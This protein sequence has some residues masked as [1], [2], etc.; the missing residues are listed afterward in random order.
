MQVLK[1]GGTSV[2]NAENIN[3]VVAIVEQ[4]VKKDTAIIVVSALAGIT[5]ALINSAL[6]AS[7]G[8]EKYKDI[9][10]Q[11]EQRHIE[12]VKAL[13]PVAQQ[14]SVLSMVKKSCNEIEDICNGIFLLREL[15]ART[16]DRMMSYGELI[17]SQVIAARCKISITDTVWKDAR[18]L[19]VTG[20]D[21]GNAPVDFAVTNRKI[22]L[23]FTA[24]QRLFVVPGFIAASTAGVTTTLGRGGSDYTAAIIAA[25]LQANIVEIW[26]DVSGMMTA[27]PRLV[28]RQK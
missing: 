3:K 25:A 2:A 10:L 28:P 20:T 19:I 13:I 8:D 14:S 5:D 9:L 4:A 15:S 11:A 16:K 6:I 22:E 18:E 1:F 7:E 17:S 24:E 21:Y 12:L 26:T 23:Y 27:D